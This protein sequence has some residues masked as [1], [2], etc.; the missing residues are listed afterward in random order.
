MNTSGPLVDI[1]V[2]SWSVAF[3]R[4]ARSSTAERSGGGN[5]ALYFFSARLSGDQLASTSTGVFLVDFQCCLR[6]FLNSLPAGEIIFLQTRPNRNSARKFADRLHHLGLHS[7]LNTIVYGPRRSQ[8]NSPCLC[9]FLV[10][11]IPS[12]SVQLISAIFQRSLCARCRITF[13]PALP[14][15]RSFQLASLPYTFV[16]SDTSQ[17]TPQSQKA[18]RKTQSPPRPHQRKTH[19]S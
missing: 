15:L 5:L 9:G 1:R 18:R 11:N 12:C 13:L 4:E 6:A 2:G 14:P 7:T 17:A 8:S 19:L 3:R 10:R 16:W